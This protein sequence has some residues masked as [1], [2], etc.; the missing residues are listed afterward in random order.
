MLSYDVGTCSDHVN[1][2]MVTCDLI[3]SNDNDFKNK[4]EDGVSVTLPP[5][6][7][8]DV[9]VGRML[10]KRLPRQGHVE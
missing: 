6:L 10:E 2:P 8:D 4:R 7:R 3:I 9:C 5:S 1:Y